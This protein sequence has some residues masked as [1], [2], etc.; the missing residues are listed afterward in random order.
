MLRFES[1]LCEI[2]VAV[3]RMALLGGS[4]DAVYVRHRT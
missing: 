4:G 2:Q 1:W 3:R